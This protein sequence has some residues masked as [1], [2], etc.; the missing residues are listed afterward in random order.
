VAAV[1]LALDLARVAGDEA[2]LLERPA[3]LRVCLQKRTRD[4]CRI[5]TACA[6]TPPPCTFTS[7]RNCACV[8]VTSK[9]WCTIIRDVS[10]PK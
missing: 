2:R 6:A 5:A 4:A 8:D 1:F 3:Q 10:R 9:G 7:A